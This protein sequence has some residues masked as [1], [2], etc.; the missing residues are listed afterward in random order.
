MTSSDFARSDRL[1]PLSA[2]G[3]KEDGTSNIFHVPVVGVGDGGARTTVADM[4]AFW[5]SLYTGALLPMDLVAAMTAPVTRTSASTTTMRMT[6]TMSPPA[7][8]SAY[9][10]RPERSPRS[11]AITG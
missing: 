11:A 6:M 4:H 5:S 8:V 7:M 3:Y 10:S 2:V 1:E 9:G